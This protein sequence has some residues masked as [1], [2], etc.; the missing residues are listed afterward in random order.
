[1]DLFHLIPSRVLR[2]VQWYGIMPYYVNDDDNVPAS[3]FSTKSSHL[4]TECYAIQTEHGKKLRQKLGNDSL[5]V[6]LCAVVA[7]FDVTL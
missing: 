3:T 1:M 6:G 5:K 4:S 2:L 7:V